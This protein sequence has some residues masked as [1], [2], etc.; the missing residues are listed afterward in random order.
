[1]RPYFNFQPKGNYV[2][3]EHY[4]GFLY[5]RT[6]RT[7][8]KVITDPAIIAKKNQMREALLHEFNRRIYNP[9]RQ[10]AN[11]GGHAVS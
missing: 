1:M 10:A 3:P 6:G 8:F 11:I 7:P 9:Y 2:L 5:P 4:E